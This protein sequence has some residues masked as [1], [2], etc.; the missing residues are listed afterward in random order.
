MGEP[1]IENP[2]SIGVTA[3]LS[4][5]GSVTPPRRRPAELQT[6]DFA[7]AWL[8]GDRK[9]IEQKTKVWERVIID[10][11]PEMK[12]WAKCPRARAPMPKT[13]IFANNHYQGYAPATVKLFEEILQ[14]PPG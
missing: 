2:I 3:Q 11:S 9:G 1:L 13:F 14:D 8:L 4:A 12:S 5:P 10:R 6:S 7:Y